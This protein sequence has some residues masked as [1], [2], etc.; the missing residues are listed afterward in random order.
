MSSL[1]KILL[2]FLINIIYCEKEYGKNIDDKCSVNLQ[3]ISGCCQNDKCVETKKC[4]SF[5]NTIYIVVAIVGAAL[6]IIFTI[7][8]LVSLYFIKKKFMEKAKAKKDTDSKEV[9]VNNDNNNK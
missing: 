4:K 7:Y 1:H 2:F 5:R 9:K 3:C 6:A 8:L